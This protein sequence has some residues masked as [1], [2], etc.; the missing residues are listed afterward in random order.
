M[1]IIIILFLFADLTV[2]FEEDMYRIPENEG[3]VEICAVLS[4][5]AS[6]DVTVNAVSRENNPPDARGRTAV[7]IQLPQATHLFPAFIIFFHKSY[8]SY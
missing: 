6:Q 5:P 8:Y 1:L 4:N 2:N 7:T 3:S